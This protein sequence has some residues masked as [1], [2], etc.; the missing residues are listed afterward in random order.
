MACFKEDYESVPLFFGHEFD[1]EFYVAHAP[2]E[3]IWK[4]FALSSLPTP[5]RSPRR[6]SEYHCLNDGT[7]DL[8]L[9]LDSYL[10]TNGVLVNSGKGLPFPESPLVQNLRAKLI[11]DC[12][13]SHDPGKHDIDKTVAIKDIPGP[14]PINTTTDCVDPTTVF[15]Y[16]I[17][18]SK[19]NC[20]GTDT[21]SDSGKTVYLHYTYF[22]SDISTVR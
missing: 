16:P 7:E 4:K 17:N 14:G 5:P 21:P 20:N 11:H 6:E 22:D 18:D 15:P 19:D 12:M 1:E 2:S 8:K 9:N 3:D 13:W 10:E